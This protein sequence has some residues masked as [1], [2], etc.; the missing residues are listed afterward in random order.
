M[1]WL[2]IDFK[3]NV[4]D[5][6]A[7]LKNRTANFFLSSSRASMHFLKSQTNILYLI[8]FAYITYILFGFFGQKYIILDSLYYLVF[9]E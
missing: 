7:Q 9:I 8:V 2:S 3:Q 1:L 5:M 6:F 4:L